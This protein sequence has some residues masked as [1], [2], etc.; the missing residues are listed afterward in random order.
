MVTGETA[1]TS[2]AEVTLEVTQPR[3][4]LYAV[5]TQDP[6]PIHIDPAFA[7]TTEMGGIIAHGTLSMNLLWSALARTFGP[8]G[9]A[10]ALLD[11]RFV[12]P[13]RVGDRVT[14]GGAKS[15]SDGRRWRVWVRNQNGEDVIA[16]SLELTA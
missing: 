7:A 14:A 11:I 1:A 4:D 12:R 5:V 2:L 6:N 16:G 10:D 15:P 8:D 3:I 13:V 9:A